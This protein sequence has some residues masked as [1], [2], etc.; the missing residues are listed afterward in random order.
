MPEGPEQVSGMQQL[1]EMFKSRG[2]SRRRR[3]NGGTRRR[4]R[5]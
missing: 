3:R 5:N 2:G 4:R 1:A